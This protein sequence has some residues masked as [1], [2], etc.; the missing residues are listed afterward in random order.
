MS[1]PYKIYLT[2]LQQCIKWQVTDSQ[3]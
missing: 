3:Q 1:L 2:T